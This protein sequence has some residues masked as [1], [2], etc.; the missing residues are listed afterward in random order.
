MLMRKLAVSRGVL[1]VPNE[2]SSHNAPT[3][4]GGGVAIVLTTL[5]AVAVMTALGPMPSNLAMTLL[6]G[7]AAVAIVGFVDD[8]RHVAASVR[9]TVHFVVVTLCAWT[10][11][12]LPQINFGIAIV[13]LGI[14]GTVCAVVFVVWFLNLFNFMDGIDGIA[15]VEAISVAG[16]A[17]ALLAWRGG[18]PSTIWFLVVLAAAVCGFL[19]WNWPPARIFMGDAGSGF[20][21]FAL[22]A[23]AW[24]TVASGQLTVWVWLILIGAFFC[25]ATVTL[26]R[27]WRRGERIYAA[28]RSH[29]YQRLSRRFGSHRKVTLGFLFVN[30]LWLAPLAWAAVTW[31]SLGAAFT[32]L[33]WTPL[34]ILAWRLGAGL[35]GELSQSV[36]GAK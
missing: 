7:G 18:D 16:I 24:A 27:R 33:A 26:A 30:L 1:D 13:D 3:P 9:L 28:H 4:R 36:V 20:L 8:H 11:G 32:L 15:S 25:D 29:A 22:G 2:R 34:V 17:V 23:I 5:A 21:G 31:P 10:L 14:A 35:P 19:I 6:V 12:R